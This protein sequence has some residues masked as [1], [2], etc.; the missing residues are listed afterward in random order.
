MGNVFWES[1]NERIEEEQ[2]KLKKMSNKDRLD[3]EKKKMKEQKFRK[4][5]ENKQKKE[6]RFKKRMD[7]RKPG[8][9]GSD[10]LL[11]FKNSVDGLGLN[12]KKEQTRQRRKSLFD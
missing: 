8:E 12:T 3:E 6:M 9:I 11:S 4:L 1:L 2:S 10:T 5:F 7:Q